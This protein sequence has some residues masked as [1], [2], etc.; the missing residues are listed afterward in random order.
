MDPLVV[1]TIDLTDVP[2]GH[3]VFFSIP[4]TNM[5]VVCKSDVYEAPVTCPRNGTLGQV[6]NDPKL[7]IRFSIQFRT[8]DQ[9][10][11]MAKSLLA[12]AE[13]MDKEHKW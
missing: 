8:A 12:L 7:H 11:Q 2:N 9:A 4:D 1:P 3:T 10:R 6:L 5:A 13:A